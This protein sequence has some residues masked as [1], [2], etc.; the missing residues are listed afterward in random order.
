M[1]ELEIDAEWGI[2]CMECMPHRHL[3]GITDVRDAHLVIVVTCKVATRFGSVRCQAVVHEHDFNSVEGTLA[4]T[5]IIWKLFGTCT[6][7][8][9][10]CVLHSLR[11]A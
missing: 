6:Q 8:P 3:A 9:V 10:L 2:H 4:L 7:Q 11:C 5:N 1:V